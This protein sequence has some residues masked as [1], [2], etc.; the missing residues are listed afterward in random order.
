MFNIAS[1]RERKP[2][3]S[4]KINRENKSLLF[5]WPEEFCLSLIQIC[6]SFSYCFNLLFVLPE[7]M[8]DRS[9]KLAIYSILQ[10]AILPVRLAMCFNFSE[11]TGPT[12]IKLR[13]IDHH[14]G[15]NIKIGFVTSS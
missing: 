3:F 4:G 13:T 9:R 11:T 10:R 8:C 15:L 2:T 1:F 5:I 7:E 14:S 12:S 6:L